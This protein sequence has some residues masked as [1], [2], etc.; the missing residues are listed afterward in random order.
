MAQRYHTNDSGKTLPCSAGPRECSFV[1]GATAEEAAKNWQD[2]MAEELIP[3]VAKAPRSSQLTTE[4]LLGNRYAGV[5]FGEQGEALPMDLP[6]DA[7]TARALAALQDA[8]FQPLIVGGAVRDA[9]LGKEPKDFDIEVHGASSFEELRSSLA[10]LGKLNLT[11]KSF[12]VMKLQIR[13]S[14][15]SLSEEI[16]LALPRRDSKVGSGHRGFTVE[17]DPQMGL[18]EATARRDL[19]VNALFWDPA[20]GR[21][22]DLH[23]GFADMEAGRLRHVSEAFS[24]DPLRVLR[25]ARFASKLGFATHPETVELSRKLIPSFGELPSERIA[26]EMAKMILEP[27]PSRGFGFLRDS[28]WGERMGIPADSVEGIA[29]GLERGREIGRGLQGTAARR[30][31]QIAVLADRLPK[32]TQSETVSYFAAAKGEAQRGLRISDAGPVGSLSKADA[33]Q[34][35][36]DNQ[37]ITARE[38]VYLDHARGATKS[39]TEKSLSRLEAL[40]ILDGPEAD[41]FDSQALIRARM[42]ADPALKS[43]SWIRTMLQ[44]ERTKQYAR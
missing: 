36:W 32:S 18:L 31:L 38:R 39:E 30:S 11:G 8:G 23:G 22:V 7:G 24:E 37:Q 26:G 15:G 34:W 12:G 41:R 29:S 6:V 35:A 2:Q 43:G 20:S 40:G 13:E 1:H 16:D 33:R 10:H 17:V 14:D 21:A 5:F 44:A 42:A 19:T 28:G 27:S 25:V 4:E 9:L 3:A